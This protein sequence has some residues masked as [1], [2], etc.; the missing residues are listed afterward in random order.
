MNKDMVAESVHP[1]LQSYISVAEGIARTFGDFCEVSVHDFTNVAASIVAI[2]NRHVTG[3]NVGSPVTNLG[4]EI[5]RQGQSGETVIVNYPNV[6]PY[7]KKMKSSSMM[8]HDEAGNLVGC[9]CINLDLTHLMMAQSVMDGL[10]STGPE[11]ESDEAFSITINDLETQIIQEG[12]EQI[13]KPIS[14][15]NKDERT[16]FL[17]YLDE[18]GLFLIKGA[19]Q[20]MA[21]LMD[22]S[23][24]TLYNY[25]DKSGT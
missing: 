6:S 23:K 20:R 18:K 3:R 24:Y 13:G 14:A 16:A 19:V 1:A 8:I 5:L 17:T 2:F 7:Q 21:K 10:T 15:M 4:L 9:L 12:I 25:L 22:V 11:K